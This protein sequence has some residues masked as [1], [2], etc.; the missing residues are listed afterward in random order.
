MMIFDYSKWQQPPRQPWREDFKAL[1]MTESAIWQMIY[2]TGKQADAVDESY[3]KPADPATG[4]PVLIA[5]SKQSETPEQYQDR[6]WE[7]LKQSA[8]G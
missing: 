6:I 4:E 2:G 5:A 1:A 3:P 7:L 8:Q